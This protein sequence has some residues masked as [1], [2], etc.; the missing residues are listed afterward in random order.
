ML[1]TSSIA[2][3]LALRCSFVRAWRPFLRPD[4]RPRTRRAQGPSRLA[5]AQASPLASMLPG[6]A[7]TAPSTARGLSWTGRHRIGLDAREG[8][9][10]VENRPRDAGKLI[11]QRNGEHIVVQ[12]LLRRLDPGFEPIAF[13]LLWP[14]LDQHDPGCLNEQAA[15]PRRA[16]PER[17]TAGHVRGGEDRANYLRRLRSRSNWSA[18]KSFKVSARLRPASGLTPRLPGLSHRRVLIE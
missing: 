18:G 3:H 7:L 16:G 4:L 9:P 2:P 5:V 6:H 12:S 15:L 10:L 14:E 11:G 8:A 13:P 17:P 1:V